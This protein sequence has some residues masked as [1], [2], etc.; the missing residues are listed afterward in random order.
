MVDVVVSFC[1]VANFGDFSLVLI[2][3]GGVRCLATLNTCFA[4]A[5][6]LMALFLGSSLVMF[7][8]D[9]A[10]VL[11]W[12]YEVVTWGLVFLL[13]GTAI[14][15][16]RKAA[17]VMDEGEHYGHHVTGVELLEAMPV[18]QSV[19]ERRVNRG[20]RKSWMGSGLSSSDDEDGLPNPGLD[21]IWD[22]DPTQVYDPPHDYE[23]GRMQ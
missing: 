3:A 1:H 17:V 10:Y 21:D 12:C 5:F 16:R 20:Y 15:L 22:D 6:A 23:R 11:L 19:M 7:E 18:P 13:G 4:V 9:C 2:H 8:T 14:F